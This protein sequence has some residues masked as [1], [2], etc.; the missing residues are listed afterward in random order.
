MMQALL[1]VLLAAAMM[2][3]AVYAQTQIPRFTAGSGKVALTRAVLIVLGIA[4]GWLS[5]AAY[6]E[7]AVLAVLAFLA[8]FGVVHVPAA[9]ILLIKRARGA[10][11]T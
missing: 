1:M 9:F 3:A 11:R 4:V 5:A 8:G 7:D 6:T 10:G 2:A